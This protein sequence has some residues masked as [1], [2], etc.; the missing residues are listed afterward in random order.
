MLV[1]V[2]MAETKLQSDI[3]AGLRCSSAAS[4]PECGSSSRQNRGRKRECCRL[5][6]ERKGQPK[7]KGDSSTGSARPP[8]RRAK[9]APKK[10][11]DSF[12][13]YAAVYFPNRPSTRTGKPVAGGFFASGSP[14]CRYAGA[15]GFFSF[16]SASPS[17]SPSPNPNP[18]S[19][20]NSNSNSNP[21]P[22]PSPNPNPNPDNPNSA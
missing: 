8:R 13:R 17:P 7:R 1:V 10:D 3:G 12:Q 18:S 21:N 6:S 22:S 14:L 16:S 20:S 5:R 15:R 9:A 4:L 2:V 11:P 19:N